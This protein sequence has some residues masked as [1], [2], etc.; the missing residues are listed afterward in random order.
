MTESRNIWSC[1]FL[2]AGDK[3]LGAVRVENSWRCISNIRLIKCGNLKIMFGN[4]EQKF[5]I[6]LV[7]Y[8]TTL[9][10]G[11]AVVYSENVGTVTKNVDVHIE[12][13][14]SLYL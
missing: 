5:L 6:T 8:F 3:F 2:F 9:T 12:P 13:L 10:K 7:Y 1:D 14:H 4:M 11:N